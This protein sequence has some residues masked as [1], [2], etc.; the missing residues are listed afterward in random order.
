MMPFEKQT[1]RKFLEALGSG[2][3]TPGGGSAAAMTAAIG[4]ALIEM[5]ARINHRRRKESAAKTRI[6]LIK[7]NRLRL[8]KLAAKDAEAFT[9]LSKLFKERQSGPKLQK[10]LRMS[11]LVPFEICGLSLKTLDLGAQEIRRTSRWLS[12]D[13]A[14]AGVLLE[15]AFCSARFNVEINLKSMT[16]QAL[17]RKTGHQLDQRQKKVLRLKKKLLRVFVR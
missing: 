8:M 14:E 3:S 16:N 13:L 5:V 1:I 4:A 6:A 11:A 9:K 7:K 10:A 15:A 17:V 2:S 12:S